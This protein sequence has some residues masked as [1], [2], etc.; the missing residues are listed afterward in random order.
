M[1]KELTNIENFLSE[2][3][4]KLKLSGLYVFNASNGFV[5]SSV[6][7]SS[8]IEAVGTLSSGCVSALEQL[9]QHFSGG[10]INYQIIRTDKEIFVFMPLGNS[11]FLAANGSE[12]LRPGY[13]LMEMESYVDEL[14]AVVDEFVKDSDAGM[15]GMDVDDISRQLDEE[16][17]KLICED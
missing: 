8:E 3:L 16:F 17:D 7:N 11:Y 5:L 15:T 10:E 2:M 13:L 12:N 14:S 4:E 9:F 6:L 1:K